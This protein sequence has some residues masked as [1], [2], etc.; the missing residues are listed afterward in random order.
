VASLTSSGININ[1]EPLS[2][3]DGGDVADPDSDAAQFANAEVRNLLEK[4]KMDY[5]VR[6]AL[7]DGAQT[8]DYCAHF[9]FDP[10]ALPYGGAFGTYQGEIMMEMVDGLNVM[11]GNPNTPLVEKQPY[12]LIVGR[13][14]CDNLSWEAAHWAK[15][16]EELIYDMQPILPEGYDRESQETAASLLGGE[17]TDAEVPASGEAEKNDVPE[18]GKAPGL[19]EKDGLDREKESF[20]QELQNLLA[21]SPELRGQ[22]IPDQVVKSM[23]LEGKSLETALTEYKVSQAKKEAERALRE[24]R[25]LKQNAASARRAPVRG[26]TGGGSTDME[27]DDDFLAGFTAYGADW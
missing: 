7:F 12:I 20:K 23:S 10:D 25:I 21:K 19:E 5:R 1:F 27:P 26:L 3:Y 4:F 17:D 16:E 15:Q 24:N 14:T 22:P 6:D 8:G 13:D 11:F 2:Y 9:Y 18:T